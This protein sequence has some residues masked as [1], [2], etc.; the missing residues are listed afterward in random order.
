[1]KRWGFLQPPS[2]W[3]GC[4]RQFREEGEAGLPAAAN[5]YCHAHQWGREEA[6]VSPWSSKKWLLCI[7]VVSG[8]CKYD[9]FLG[10]QWPNFHATFLCNMRA[11]AISMVAR[12]S[13]PHSQF[14]RPLS[15]VCMPCSQFCTLQGRFRKWRIRQFWWAW[16]WCALSFRWVLPKKACGNPIPQNCSPKEDSMQTSNHDPTD[17]VKGFIEC[18]TIEVVFGCT[19]TSQ[20]GPSANFHYFGCVSCPHT[21]QFGLSTSATLGVCLV[22]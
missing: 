18:Q 11:R 20:S 15:R 1:M 7:W 14:C 8:A 3:E 6:P 16:L 21:T 9:A 22:I 19:P 17:L 13:M 12:A 10:G 5:Y 2:E 4:R